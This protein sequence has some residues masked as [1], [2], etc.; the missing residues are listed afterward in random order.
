MKCS[1]S[2]FYLGGITGCTA[3]LQVGYHGNGGRTRGLYFGRCLL[4]GGLCVPPFVDLVAPYVSG[5][6]EGTLDLYAKVFIPA[7][8]TLVYVPSRRPY[9]RYV[10]HYSSPRESK[11]DSYYVKISNFTSKISRPVT[12]AGSYTFYDGRTLLSQVEQL[13]PVRWQSPAHPK[14]TGASQ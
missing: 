1:G 3:V 2:Q 5:L 11:G 10:V 12:S 6:G 9:E 13:R 8:G 7:T 4:C 14:G